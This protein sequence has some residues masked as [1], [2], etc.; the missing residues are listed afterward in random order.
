MLVPERVCFV[1]FL[2]LSYIV[3]TILG[4]Y[5]FGVLRVNL[6]ELVFVYPLSSENELGI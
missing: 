3:D 2:P 1:A 4:L 5:F 6:L